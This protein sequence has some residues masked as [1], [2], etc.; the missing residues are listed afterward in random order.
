MK[1][2]KISDIY[3]SNSSM[4]GYWLLLS[5]VSVTELTVKVVVDPCF[6]RRLQKQNMLCNILAS[7]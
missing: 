7:I 3:C 1:L 2:A 6:E 4:L 5:D